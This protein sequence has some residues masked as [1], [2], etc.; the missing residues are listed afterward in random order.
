MF[1]P[2]YDSPNAYTIEGLERIDR[3][4]ARAIQVFGDDDSEPVW[5]QR[6]DPALGRDD[7]GQYLTPVGLAAG[8]DEGLR[9][10]L[11]ILDRLAPTVTPRWKPRR[12]KRRRR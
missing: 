12:A 11:E 4:I 3:L 6:N 10:L 5:W 8:S 2:R 7:S 1:F 9:Q